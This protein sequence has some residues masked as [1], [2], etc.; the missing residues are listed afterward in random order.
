M[1]Q[2]LFLVF[3]GLVICGGFLNAQTLDEAVLRAALKIGTDLPAGA[4]VAVI[5]FRSKK[6]TLSAYVSNELHGAI[7]RNRR[8]TPVKPDEGQLQSIRGELRLTDAG[9]IEEESARNIG[10]LLGAQYLVT[11]SLERGT[12]G[13]ELLVTAVDAESAEQKSRY[14]ALVSPSD[15]MLAEQ[16]KEEARID[17]LNRREQERTDSNVRRNKWVYLGGMLGIG[18][19]KYTFYGRYDTYRLFAFG[20]VSEFA[21]LPFFS[22]ETGLGYAPGGSLVIPLLA[23][24]GYRFSQI[25]LS[26][27]IGYTI[28]LISGWGGGFTLGGTVGFHVGPGIL[29][30]KMLGMLGAKP[31]YTNIRGQ[32]D[33]LD[34]DS[35]SGMIWFVGYKW[36]LGKTKEATWPRGL[37]ITQK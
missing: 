10:Q 35:S 20:F 31:D 29:F 24:F 22:I 37:T 26:F 25:E 9:E 27:D 4:T 7:L 18:H 8:L 2:K 19:Q 17:E 13:Y 34:D 15:V 1:K 23:K 33:A 6:E 16:E 21:L 36:G 12:S 3:L 28:G 14:S 11:G 32:L 30:V 5:H